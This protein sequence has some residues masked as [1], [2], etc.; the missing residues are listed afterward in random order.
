V[1]GFGVT[2][3]PTTLSLTTMTSNQAAIDTN[4]PI[5]LQAAPSGKNEANVSGNDVSWSQLLRV[6]E[7]EALQGTDVADQSTRSND[8]D[9]VSV[10]KCGVHEHV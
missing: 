9:V 3:S 7:Q 2:L 10:T 8:Y 5:Q 6:K 4:S 1:L